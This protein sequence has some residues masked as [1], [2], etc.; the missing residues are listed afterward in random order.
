MA[1]MATHDSGHRV[2]LWLSLNCP[3]LNVT[4]CGFP[5]IHPGWARAL[6]R[7]RPGQLAP[8]CT[9]EAIRACSLLAKG[10]DGH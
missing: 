5:T 7:V 6:A 1:A 3:C 8:L 4:A 9:A 2:C 10:V